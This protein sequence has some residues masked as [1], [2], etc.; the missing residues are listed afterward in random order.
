VEGALA[1]NPDEPE[2]KIGW[3]DSVTADEWWNERWISIPE[4]EEIVLSRYPR[5]SI[6]R[7]KKL[8]KD[9]IA[10]GEVRPRPDPID[11]FVKIMAAVRAG[12]YRREAAPDSWPEDPASPAYSEDDFIYWLDWQLGEHETTESKSRGGRETSE[13]E[14]HVPRLRD[15]NDI[16]RIE[17]ARKLYAHG[18]ISKTAAV[19]EVLAPGMT[20]RIP[21]TLMTHINRLRKK[22]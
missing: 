14:P 4:M 8:V 6:G 5:V 3:R 15:A 19:K 17:E 20:G 10:S 12:T 22:V 9:A 2:R 21:K 7:A 13:S 1:K 16:L 11:L 18:N